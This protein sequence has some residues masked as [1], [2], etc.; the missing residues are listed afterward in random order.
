MAKNQTLQATWATVIIII[1]K[2]F[3]QSITIVH[4]LSRV[5]HFFHAIHGLYDIN[6]ILYFLIANAYFDEVELFDFQSNKWETKN[7]WNYPFRNG[8]R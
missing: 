2:G 5:S 1:G 6:Y 3:Y 8:R 4:L 7:E